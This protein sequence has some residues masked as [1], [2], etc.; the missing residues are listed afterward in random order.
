MSKIA[1]I[2]PG[3]GAQ[4]CGMGADFYENSELA[5][6]IFDEMNTALDFDVKKICFEENE[7]INQTEYTQPAMVTT[8]VAMAKVLMEKGIKPDMVAGLSLGE[9]AAI[10]VA[11]GM[12]T[13]D[14]VLAVRKRG[15]LMEH[16]VPDGKGTMAAILGMNGEA[17]AEAIQDIEG[18]SVANYNC[19]GQIVITG[20]KNAV[21]TACDKLKEAGAKRAIELNV[22][23][24]FHSSM[25]SS[26]S[27]ELDEML[28]AI[29]FGK[30]NI[31]YVTNV[32][33]SVITDETKIKDLLVKQMCSSVYW[34]QSVEKM[35]EEGVD[36]FVEIGPGKTLAG[37]V[38]KISKE[39]KIVNI[40]TWDDVE[41][42][43]EELK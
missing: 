17:V 42:K 38:K 8:C 28:S 14:A 5:K 29:S 25:L 26:A 2:F 3:Q 30:L 40:Q 41:N 16:A 24:P 9:Y 21:L 33:A 18:V 10:E 43:L 20:E 11:G 19:P 7:E 13:K 27:E 22:S 39:V 23:G 6:N 1:F 36:T 12:T 4:R 31:P 32:D 37:F 34:Q 15:I 35:I